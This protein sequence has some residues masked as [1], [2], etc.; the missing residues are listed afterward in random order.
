ML[1]KNAHFYKR[2]I[3]IIDDDKI[4][5]K[6]LARMLEK[7]DFEVYIL[8]SGKTCLEFIQSN[9]TEIVLLDIMMPDMSGIEV[10]KQI[11]E[12]FK[13]VELPVIM[14]T[15]KSETTDVTEA[16]NLGANDYLT[17]PVT[18]DI[19]VARIKTQL[20]IVDLNRDSMRTKELE[21]LNAMIT[22]F[23]H[24]INNPLTIALLNLKKDVS[25]IDQRALDRSIDALLRIA[26]IVKKIDGLSSGD[27]EMTEYSESSKM[28]DLKE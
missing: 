25:K 9:K 15:A 7:K 20:N 14:V 12:T 8:H 6:F 21:T 10:L 18:I 11:R 3:L 19:A 16:L 22:T 28:I 24:E 17:K 13:P 2:R 26:S 1:D 23:N 5:S 27:F 4:N